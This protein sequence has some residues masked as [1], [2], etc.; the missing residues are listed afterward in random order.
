MLLEQKKKKNK[1]GDHIKGQ[2]H[3]GWGGETEVP[4]LPS[5]LPWHLLL[6]LCMSCIL[7]NKLET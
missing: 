3:S 7:Y 1:A 4:L 6:Q 2:G 5:Y